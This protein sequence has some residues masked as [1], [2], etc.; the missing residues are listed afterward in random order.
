[1]LCSFSELGISDDH[2]GIIE[3]PA[4]APIGADIRDYLGLDDNAIEVDLTPNRADCLGIRGIAREVGVLNNLD[5]CE[6]EVAAV[7]ATI[8]DY[9]E[10]ME[11][12]PEYENFIKNS[13][14]WLNTKRS[15]CTNCN[16]LCSN[17][18]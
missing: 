11:S 4:D 1:M 8:D 13:T 3:L 9:Y 6:P 15:M 18:S 14:N 16:C 5:V 2:D 12:N 17:C 7:D 10:L